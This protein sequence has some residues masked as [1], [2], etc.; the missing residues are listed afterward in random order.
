MKQK[1]YIAGL[2]YRLSQEDERQGESVS[3][4]N[5]RA[6]LRKYAEE[7]GFEIHGEYI[8]DG[9]SGTTFDRPE[10]QRLLDDAKTGIINT[11][12]VKDLS[13]FGRNYIE[14][15]QY[16]DYVF[17]AFGI[18]FI[19]IQ[20]NVDT[21]NRDSNAM[22]MMP[23]MNIFNEW[24]AANTSKKI[25]TVLKAN[26]REGKYH[27]RKAPYGY[28]KSDT[29]KNA[30]KAPYGY[31]KSDTEKKTPIIDEEAAAVVKRIFEM[32]AS[33]LSPHK[34]ADILNA[35]GILNPSRYCLERYGVVGRRENVGLWSFC[36]VNSILQNPTYL[37]HMVQQR[38]G[39]VSYKNHK[40]YI[41]DES[42]WV[43]VRNTHEPIISQELWDKVREVEK[44]VAQGRKTKRGYTHPLSGF[45][46]CADCGGKMKLNYINRKGK[47][48]FNFNCG[49][50]VRL[51]K[52]YCFS[53]FIQAKDIEAI[54]LDDIRTMAQRIVLD[55][56]T[57]RED[58]IRHNAEL[59]DK[60]I[61]SA[62][63]ELQVKRKRTEEL[64]R[65]MQLAYEDRL[66]GKVPEDICIGFIQKYSEEQK[67]V[68][69]EI[70]E[71]E[72]RLTETTNTI[73]SADE[74]IRNIK[75]YLEAP[76]LT[77]EMCYELLD[78]VVVGGHPKHTGKERVIDIV[79]KV[80]IASVLRYKLNK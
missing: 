38:D 2:Y 70:A 66:K 78:R 41:K 67:K 76:E 49:N 21:E 34:I 48:D 62:K 3:I 40:R 11:I 20:D 25:R 59:A 75:K 46:F 61:K 29:E 52:S 43:I 39:T 63:K 64:S 69:A 32:R 56:K 72:E 23:I 16:V 4:D 55:E 71:L 80:D 31:V 45:L 47:L 77:R 36:G 24:H 50:H 22:E 44:S 68:D 13:R 57:I 19:A 14:V 7:H 8:D 18:R 27:A 30:R 37:G 42:E 53:H 5:Q 12:I 35:E 6:I 17:P 54:V 74:F 26:A 51:G 10:V 28:V 79:Y 60:A 15:G 65:L 58:F 73:Q 1:H 9:V 33:G